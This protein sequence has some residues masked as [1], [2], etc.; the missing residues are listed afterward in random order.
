MELLAQTQGLQ[1]IDLVAQIMMVLFPLAVGG[2]W[3][4]RKVSQ[5]RDT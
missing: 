3:V 4:G 5:R 1:G 2:Y